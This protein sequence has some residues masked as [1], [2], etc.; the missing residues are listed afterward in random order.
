M[1]GT[2]STVGLDRFASNFCR[3]DTFTPS[4][5]ASYRCINF[6]ARRRSCLDGFEYC[7]DFE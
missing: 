7:E 4:C 2:N 5:A 3:L 1:P 6:S